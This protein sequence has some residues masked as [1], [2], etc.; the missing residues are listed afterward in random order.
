MHH[1]VIT[2]HGERESSKYLNCCI[3]N[4]RFQY[5]IVVRQNNG[6]RSRSIYVQAEHKIV[7]EREEME[8]ISMLDDHS[9][10]M[11]CRLHN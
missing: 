11:H 2:K 10:N 5:P 8:L 6:V 4:R 3:Q 9:S 7:S 1:F